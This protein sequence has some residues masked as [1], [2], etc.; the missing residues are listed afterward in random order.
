MTK[1]RDIESY[2]KAGVEDLGGACTKWTGTA[3]V[4]D[5]IIFFPH[6]VKLWFVETKAPGEVVERALQVFWRGFLIGNGQQYAELDTKVK[7]DS[8][9]AQRARE[10]H[11][12]KHG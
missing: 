10:I 7:V 6:G 3:G 5:R 12:A 4:P 1:E 9:L 2:L 11:R 8:W